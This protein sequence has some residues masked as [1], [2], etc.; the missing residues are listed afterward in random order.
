MKVPNTSSL[1]QSNYILMTTKEMDIHIIRP[2]CL[3]P[4]WDMWKKWPGCIKHLK[5]GTN[6]TGLL[7]LGSAWSQESNVS[8]SIRGIM[9]W[10]DRAVVVCSSYFQSCSWHEKSKNKTGVPGRI[11]RGTAGHIKN[12][13]PPKANPHPYGSYWWGPWQKFSSYYMIDIN[14]QIRH[15]KV[16]DITKYLIQ[17]LALLW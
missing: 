16:T 2:I 3:E 9:E 5:A 8:T 6:T 13:I 17:S 4:L 12:L 14:A 7:K 11:R 15:R 10:N 1:L